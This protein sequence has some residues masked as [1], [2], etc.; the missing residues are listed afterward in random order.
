M[1]TA[2]KNSAKATMMLD[3]AKPVLGKNRIEIFTDGATDGANPGPAGWGFVALFLNETGD[4]I[5]KVERKGASRVVST[6][7][8]AEMAGALNALTFA[9]AQQASGAWP[10]CP[11]TIISDS[12]ILVRGMTAWMPGWLAK[13]WR[14]SNKQEVANRD[15]W[16]RLNVAS[17]GMNVS[18]HWVEGHNGVRWNERADALASEGAREAARKANKMSA[19]CGQVY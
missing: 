11:V 14:K 2:T 18:W 8:R 7:N 6:N 5:E 16:E 12:Q 10:V 4:L 13:G 17:E 19:L 3:G 15:L 9:A 1:T